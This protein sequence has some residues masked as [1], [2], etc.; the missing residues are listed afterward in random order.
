MS[1][2]D[3]SFYIVMNTS[4]SFMAFFAGVS[5]N[6][7]FFFIF[8]FVRNNFVYVDDNYYAI[9]FRLDEMS[10]GNYSAH[11]LDHNYY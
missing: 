7:F 1:K 11:Y 6:F 3:F 5:F 2:S 9:Y 10:S 8:I 4:I